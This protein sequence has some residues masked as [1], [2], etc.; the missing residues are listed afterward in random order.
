MCY[1]ISYKL[2][3]VETLGVY[4]YA[5]AVFLH[6]I[7]IHLFNSL[8]YIPATYA[9]HHTQFHFDSLSLLSNLENRGAL[10]NFRNVDCVLANQNKVHDMQANLKTTNQLIII[11]ILY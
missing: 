11:I 6:F 5:V 1:P 4:D 3:C 8:G 9:T 10:K 7:T 2:H